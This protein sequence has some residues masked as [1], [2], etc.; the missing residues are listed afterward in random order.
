MRL[1]EGESQI[2]AAVRL[3]FAIG[4]VASGGSLAASD[5]T[6]VV[7]AN[8]AATAPPS[9]TPS[10]MSAVRAAG[11]PLV[12]TVS[13]AQDLVGR[14]MYADRRPAGVSGSEVRFSDHP[15]IPRASN[16]AA[17]AAFGA[18]QGGLPL[19][20]SRVTSGYGY[21]YHPVLG[22]WR[23]HGGVDLAA[24]TG[25]PV[26]S[27]S[28]GTVRRAGWAGGYGLMVEIDH[29]EGVQTRF[30]HLSQIAVQ[31]GQTVS[32]GDVIGRVGTT[33]RSTG[34]HLHF[35]TRVNGSATNPMGH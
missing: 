9:T 19:S 8:A 3:A 10:Q 18:Y 13:R 22:G 24:A 27:T 34:P 23:M 32:R 4:V 25:T 17:A 7:A 5:G 14:T 15:V 30:G 1:S 33:G 26:H 31:P 35:E 12:V 21:R 6:V 28:A 16:G 29:G 11:A 2:L 20:R